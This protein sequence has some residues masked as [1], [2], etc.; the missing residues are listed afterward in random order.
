MAPQAPTAREE[1]WTLKQVQGDERRTCSFVDDVDNP[2]DLGFDGGKPAGY[3]DGEQ[4]QFIMNVGDH[5]N[6]RLEPGS[7][8]EALSGRSCR[9]DVG[10]EPRLSDGRE[11]VAPDPHGSIV[12]DY[13]NN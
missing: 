10:I 11:S 12:F 3:A 1:G 5:D 9:H 4:R 13:D 8:V 6:R 7:L 2:S